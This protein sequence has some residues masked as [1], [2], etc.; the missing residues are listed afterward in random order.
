LSVLIT[1]K[2]EVKVEFHQVDMMQMVHN[3]WYFRWFELGRT[4][5]LEHLFPMKLAVK[6][7]MV[8]PVV[9]NHCEYHHPAV[10]GDTLV[11]T[12]RHRMLEH[13]SGRFT[14][15]HTI[16]NKKTKVEL[17]DGTSAVTVIDFNTKRLIKEIPE[18]IWNEY[19]MLN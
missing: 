4:E 6:N 11:V 14:F 19:L 17:C 16:S 1:R 15:E 2:T 9:M 10:Y 18:N 7:K 12:T 8:A 13:W 3:S 5:I